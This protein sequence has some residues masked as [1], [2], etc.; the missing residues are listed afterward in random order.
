MRV[1]LLITALLA[2]VLF[3]CA[4]A[5]A[6]AIHRSVVVTRGKAWLVDHVPYSQSRYHESYRT[7]CSGFVSMCWGLTTGSGEPLSLST[8]TLPTTKGIASTIATSALLPGDIMVDPGHHTFLFVQWADSSRKSMIT[9]EEGGSS[10]GTLSRVRSLA[11]LS[12]GY[13]AYRRQGIQSDPRYSDHLE[14]I[15][16]TVRLPGLPDRYSS[17]VRASASTFTSASAVVIASADDWNSAITAP[18][19]AGVV[20]GP[21][22]F[23][24]KD[25]LPSAVAAE[26]RRLKAKSAYIVGS[27]SVISTATLNAIRAVGPWPERVGAVGTIKNSIAVMRRAVQLMGR[28]KAGSRLWDG[29][30]MLADS[31]DLADVQSAAALSARKRWPL[32]LT[33]G[34]TL[35]ADTRVAIEDITPSCVVVIGGPTVVS[36]KAVATVKARVKTVYR[37]A[38]AS[39]YDTAFRLAER[40]VA[41][42]ATWVGVGLMPEGDLVDSMAGSVAQARKGSFLLGTPRRSLSAR[43]AGVLAFHG[44]WVGRLRVFGS[45]SAI[46]YRVRQA[47]WDVIA[48]SR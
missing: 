26:I 16:Q 8:R 17:A 33:S 46:D 29:T 7:D 28:D 34:S 6:M 43:V 45:E 5:P 32:L 47:A 24:S 44:K 40:A 3:A 11:S 1:R 37:L 23:V 48:G 41:S 2:A 10:T 25:T 20:K 39:R 27:S 30:I 9:L 19:L 12:P 18:A 22:L 35:N 14:L 4:Q 38:G 42:G 13:R 31:G 21:L 15:E 36:D